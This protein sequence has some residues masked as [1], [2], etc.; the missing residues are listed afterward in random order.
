MS[1][2]S[3]IPN[4]PGQLTLANYYALVSDAS[5]YKVLGITFIFAGLTVAVAM[6]LGLVFAWLVERTDMPFKTAAVSLI[7]LGILI[8]TF[9]KA[10]GWVLLLHPR[11][12]VFNVLLMWLFDLRTPPLNIGSI[13]GMAF[14]QGL[15]LT[16]VAYIMTAAALRSMNPALIE[17]AGV[18]GVARIRTILRIE[19]PLVWPAITAVTI[20]LFTIGISAFDI[21]AI[22]GIGNN[23]FTFS[24]A[25]YFMVNPT[26]GLPKYGLSGAFGTLMIGFSLMLMIPYFLALKRSHR[27]EI[28]SGKGYQTRP[29]ELGRCWILGWSIIAIYIL[30]AFILPLLAV[31]WVSLMPYM[32]APSVQALTLMSLNHYKTL[33]V[34]DLADALRN[35]VFLMLAVPTS[36]LIASAAI[37]W[38]VT[39]SHLKWR[40]F[41]DAMAFLPHPVPNLLFAL[42][43]AYAGLLV[44][45]IVP[46]YGTIYT[47]MVAYVVCWISFGTRVLNST[48]LQVHRELEEAAQVAGVSALRILLKVMLPLIRPALVYS[49]IW[50]SLLVYRELT[51]AVLLASAGNQVVSTYIWGRWGGGSLGEAAA[52]AVVMLAIM[53]PFVVLLWLVA[54]R[55]RLALVTSA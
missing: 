32:Q 53:S 37:S 35:T 23:I 34:G 4:Q 43:I 11:I 19:L 24:T 39:R 15:T 31:I 46:I 7:S 2:G 22:I 38:V 29:I 3:G 5:L 41:I 42:A 33:L 55:Q 21:P 17:A 8:P 16:P 51:M 18:H 26:E 10:M 28:V 48:M 45:N 40:L 9:L 6:P 44:W 27:Y 47:L 52:A 54:R 36:V 13:F 20:W 12:G 14:I 49:W 25:L 1:L 50:T 30:L